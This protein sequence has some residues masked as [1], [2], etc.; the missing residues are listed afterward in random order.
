M[1]SDTVEI[2]QD[3]KDF[4]A[5]L[6]RAAEMWPG[7]CGVQAMREVVARHRISSTPQ[8]TDPYEGHDARE[9]MIYNP[10][11]GAQGTDT[12]K[13]RIPPEGWWC[14][15]AAGHEGPCAA[16]AIDDILTMTDEQ[17]QAEATP[18]DIGWAK[19]FKAGMRA[20]LSSSPPSTDEGV[21]IAALEEA[22][23]TARNGLIG[24][25]AIITAGNNQA[26]AAKAGE[27]LLACLE[28]IDAALS[29]SGIQEGGG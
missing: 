14:S 4:V 21:R 2:T 3:D 10:Y 9:G 15:R 13:C 25:T 18:E 27:R 19:G 29:P 17:V 16:R 8:G 1:T 11:W 24:N 5:E 6:L 7:H 26:Q 23:R 20:A 28:Q 12:D 22:L